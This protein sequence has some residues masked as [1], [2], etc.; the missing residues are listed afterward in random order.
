MQ[1]QP[2][3]RARR[4]VTGGAAAL[5]MTA[6]LVACTGTG[7]D[8]PATGKPV[9]GGTL[10]F[11]SN[12][13]TDCLDPHQ[14][15]RD[16]ALLYSRP[17]LDSLVNLTDDGQIHPW[18]AKSWTVSKDQRT[19]TFELRDDVTFSNGEKFDAAAVK[20]NFDHIVDPKTASSS[21]VGYIGPFVGAKVVDDDTV[22]VKFSSPYSAF[23]PSIATA[24][25]GMEAPSTLKQ[26]PAKLCRVIV[27]TGPFLSKGGYVPQ[28]GISYVKNPDYN[29][30]PKA[31]AHQGPAHLDAL[32]I[33]I[34]PEDSV[35]LGSL[36]S[37]EVDAIASVPPV[38]VSTVKADKSLY[39]DSVPAPGGN[40][41]YYPN[42]TNGVFSDIAVRKAFRAGIDFDTLIKSLYR[43]AFEPANSPIAPNTLYYDKTQEAS[44]KYDPEAAAKLLD[45]AGWIKGPDGIRVKDGKKLKIRLPLVSGEREQRDT[46]AQQVQAEAAKLG[47]DMVIDAVDFG[48]FAEAVGTADYDLLEISW[49]RAAP[50]VLRS[51]FNSEFIPKGSINTD[52][53]RYTDPTID[54]V[55]S[56]ALATNDPA[57]LAGL[58]ATA[59]QK[60]A[61][62]AIV[63][64]QYVF[65]YILGARAT[66]RGIGW[67]P[68]AF[69]TF[70]DAWTTK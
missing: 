13:D 9:D 60:V 68:Q 24:L 61:D 41:N 28:Q 1:E 40:Y 64:P 50:D 3:R 6:S 56:D 21:A 53:S 31:A 17:I 39:I 16:V 30:A 10:T 38:N 29:W 2:L 43:G 51:L 35:R 15:P 25:F 67:E 22:T 26:D 48:R 49:Q 47:F 62:K 63:F 4:I 69:P 32:K 12:A 65:S 66:A 45:E 8:A 27:G 18:L 14:S 42:T 44:Y 54:K 19:Y 52:F 34:V 55:T 58:Y 33:T 7:T 57:K 59:Q 37:G 70:Y 46:L 11:A 20:A 5:T 36:T 23:L